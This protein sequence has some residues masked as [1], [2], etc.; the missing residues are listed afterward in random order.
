MIP[1]WKYIIRKQTPYNKVRGIIQQI[2]KIKYENN[3]LRFNTDIHQI[4]GKNIPDNFMSIPT[5]RREGECEQLFKCYQ[6]LNS[7][8]QKKLQLIMCLLQQKYT[9]LKYSPT[10]IYIVQYLMLFLTVS[11]T[12]VVINHMI[13]DS[14]RLLQD[15]EQNNKAMRQLSWYFTLQEVDFYKTAK[16]FFESVSQLSN[17]MKNIIEHFN[18]IRFDYLQFF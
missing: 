6:F 13:Q 11:E 14:I 7:E 10:I 12:Y 4:F 1:K 17:T 9:Q 15:K 3:D 5:F 16:I 2:F 18:K 8:G